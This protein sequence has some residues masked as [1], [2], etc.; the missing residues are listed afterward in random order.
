MLT[1]R[2]FGNIQVREFNKGFLFDLPIWV[3]VI[4]S[5]FFI[6]PMYY[7]I[8]FPVVEK[9]LNL[10]KETN[11]EEDEEEVDEEK[12]EEM[13]TKAELNRKLL[14]EIKKSKRSYSTT[15]QKNTIGR[16]VNSSLEN[17]PLIDKKN[18]AAKSF[19]CMQ[20]GPSA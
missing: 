2:L 15:L 9:K 17:D 5:A 10:P 1:K 13:V 19:I 20:S 4:M 16:L 3:K 11:D 14:K 7:W 6:L 18:R 12:E 8:I